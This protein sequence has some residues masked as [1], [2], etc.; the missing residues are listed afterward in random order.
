MPS[1]NNAKANNIIRRLIYAKHPH[2]DPAEL[3]RILAKDRLKRVAYRTAKAAKSKTA[4]TANHRRTSKSPT[5]SPSHSRRS[6]TNKS[7]KSE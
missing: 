4:K 2:V 1:I 3:E 7:N 6:T 5:R